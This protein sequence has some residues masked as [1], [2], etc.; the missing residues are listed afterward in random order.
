M[1][2]ILLA[3][4]A[5]LLASAP[6]TSS[7]AGDD[8][9]EDGEGED[10]DDDT[11][12][13]V[14]G[15]DDDDDDAPSLGKG[16]DEEEDEDEEEDDGGGATPS[17]DLDPKDLG[18]LKGG[19][20]FGVGFS[21]GTINGASIK[22]WPARAHGIVL[23]IGAPPSILNALAVS[24]Q[25]RIHVKPVIVP[26]SPVSLHFNLGPALRTRI[27]W[28][29]NGTFI[30]LAGGL[31]LG[32]SVTVANVPAEFFVEAIPSYGGGVSP[33]GVGLG[34]SVDGVAGVRFYVGK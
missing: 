21:V 28:F 3:L 12:P 8:E 22:L 19:G 31:A 1:H 32:A 16:D 4:L 33:A 26:G 15:D 13:W 17:W 6:P 30:E 2:R 24:I 23:H 9:D 29:S 5:L 7:L 25:Y 20:L 14:E 34:F 18:T 27:V 10:E 11:P